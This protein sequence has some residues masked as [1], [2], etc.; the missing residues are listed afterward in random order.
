MKMK[1]RTNSKFFDSRTS[2]V[3]IYCRRPRFEALE[4]RCLL[5]AG[6]AAS[7][8]HGFLPAQ[9]THAYGVDQIPMVAGQLPGAGQTIAILEELDNPNF[10]DSTDPSFATSD[11]AV[12]DRLTRLP[13]PPSFRVISYN[14]DTRE[15]GPRVSPVSGETADEFA[16]D[17]EWAHAIAPGASIIVVE[18]SRPSHLGGAKT[19]NFAA[20]LPGV[21]VVSSS[22]GSVEFKEEIDLDQYFVTPAGHQGVTYFAS[23]GDEKEGFHPSYPANSPNIV[24]VGG[25]YLTLDSGRDYDS[26]LAWNHS[27]G[28]TSR[29]ETEPAYQLGVNT[30]GYRQTPDVAAIGSPDTGVAVYNSWANPDTGW[31]RGAIGGTSLGAPVWAGMVAIAN[32]LRVQAGLGTLDGVSQTLPRLYQL[33]SADFHSISGVQPGEL[34]PDDPRS[35]DLP[36]GYNLF[37]G[38]GSPVANLLVPDLA[39]VSP[40]IGSVVVAQSRRLMTWNAQD[41]SGVTSA[42]LTIDGTTISSIHGPYR[43]ASGVNFSGAFGTMSTGTHHYTITVDDTLGYTSQYDGTFSVTGPTIG[44]VVVVP[45]QGRMTW[46][47]QDSSNVISSS[48]AVDG[49]TVSNVRGPYRTASGVNFSGVFGG[50]SAGSHNYTITAN[51][52]LGNSS[53]YTGSFSVTG[54][55]IGSVVVIPSLRLMTWNVQD[56]SSV[57]SSSLTI[58]D[59]PVSRIRGPYMATC[60]ANF[61]GTW[62]HLSFGTHRYVITA[63]DVAGN[64]SQYAGTFDVPGPLAAT[65]IPLHASLASLTDSLHRLL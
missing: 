35:R 64:W 34:V 32:Q 27:Q 60:G 36:E 14:P 31:N 23:S 2:A 22:I 61:S 19:M 46:N 16:L 57:T 24:S 63:R 18:D 38:L 33:N 52:T 41:S 56:S 17:V 11:L 26:E 51:D 30:T 43:A 4:D 25:T 42:S 6:G 3:S 28:G 13:D 53:Q 47:V 39:G 48:L 9:I 12:F 65:A 58:D 10:L 1:F 49:T 62:G 59:T 20:S 37:T 44:G 7:E 21:S 5:S 40:A 45:S 29:Y 15:V 8:H 50:L 54:P 55:T